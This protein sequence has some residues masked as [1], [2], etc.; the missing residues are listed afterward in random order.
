M[1]YKGRIIEDK[2]WLHMRTGNILKVPFKED[3]SEE[4]L[5]A[6][7]FIQDINNISNSF[8]CLVEGLNVK[9]I[10]YK[11]MRVHVELD[12]NDFTWTGIVFSITYDAEESDREANARIERE[13]S[14]IDCIEAQRASLKKKEE[15]DKQ[16][17]KQDAI[18]NAIKLLINEGY[19]IVAKNADSKDIEKVLEVNECNI[20]DR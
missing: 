2:K 15:E 1:E 8:D 4:D 11:N 18:K 13:K 10:K 14:E 19:T 6:D 20:I 9:G 12:Y 17:V 3:L 7:M 5:T 16:K